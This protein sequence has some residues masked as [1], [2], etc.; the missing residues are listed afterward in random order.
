M[1]QAI[2][3]SSLALAHSWRQGNRLAVDA[4]FVGLAEPCTLDNEA[5]VTECQVLLHLLSCTVEKLPADDAILDLALSLLS[6]SSL[7]E[8]SQQVSAC[9]CLRLA[10]IA[11]ACGKADNR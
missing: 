4:A 5:A 11:A 8:V 9:A 3:T 7:P 6:D 2:N 1:Y 10:L